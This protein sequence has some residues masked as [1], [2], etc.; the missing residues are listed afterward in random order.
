MRPKTEKYSG[1][2]YTKIKSRAGSE[3]IIDSVEGE[4][5]R[6]KPKRGAQKVPRQ[7]KEWWTKKRKRRAKINTGKRHA[8]NN[9]EAADRDKDITYKV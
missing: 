2:W 6:K 3:M 4:K 1:Y 7:R 9:W 5:K 8:R